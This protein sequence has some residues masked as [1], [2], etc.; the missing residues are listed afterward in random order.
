MIPEYY[1]IAQVADILSISKETLR[2][3]DKRAKKGSSKKGVRPLSAPFSFFGFE[4]TA[5]YFARPLK[6]ASCLSIKLVTFSLKSS[7]TS[8]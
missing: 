4:S 5:T 6:T 8:F 2:R 7:V 1:T 3:W